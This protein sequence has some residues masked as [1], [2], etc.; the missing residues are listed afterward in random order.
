VWCQDPGADENSEARKVHPHKWAGPG[1]RFLSASHSLHNVT[2]DNAAC[3]RLIETRWF[4]RNWGGRIV[5]APDQNAKTFYANLAGGARFVTTVNAG[6]TGEGGDIVIIDD[7]IDAREAGAPSRLALENCIRWFAESMPTRVTDP[8]TACVILVMQRL[9]ELD[10]SGYWLSREIGAEHLMLPARFEPDHPLLSR[11]SLS[12]VDPRKRAGEVL[13][14]QHYPQEALDALSSRMTPYAAAGQLQQRPAPREGGLFKP[15]WF[16]IIDAVPAGATSVRAWDL[17]ATLHKGAGDPDYTVGLKMSRDR[18][19]F[20]TIEHVLRLR[21]TADG[22]ERAIRATASQDGT[23]VEIVIPQDPGQAGKGQASYL[24]R[25][26]AGHRVHAARATGDK[27]TRAAPFAS[28]AAAGNVRLLRGPWNQAFL[29]EVASFPMGRHDDQVDAAADAF[30]RL[31]LKPAPARSVP[32]FHM[33][34]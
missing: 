18:Q 30:L 24:T 13:W 33:Q 3:R 31:S 28:Q 4:R 29:E 23:R 16:A 5:F 6:V 11:T 2:R 19:G 27:A 8:M 12:F 1:V 22:V 26:L 10:L 20:F 9:H 21:E 25:L 7:P 17:A 32:S 14:P 15:E 34:R